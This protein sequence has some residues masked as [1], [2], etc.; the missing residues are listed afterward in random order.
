VQTDLLDRP[1]KEVLD[2]SISDEKQLHVLLPNESLSHVLKMLSGKKRA[3]VVAES[4][5]SILTQTDVLRFALTNALSM[6]EQQVWSLTADSIL[7][8]SSKPG[9]EHDPVKPVTTFDSTHAVTALKKM[10]LHHIN[11]IA[12]VNDHNKLVASLSTSDLKGLSHHHLNHLHQPVL[13]FLTAVHKR[14]PEPLV[15]QR[16]TTFRQ[17]VE[18]L[19]EFGVHRVWVVDEQSVPVGVITQ[20]DLIALLV[21]SAKA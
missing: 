19:L 1:I 16:T 8:A 17:I 13:M 4:Q 9:S 11:G 15:C 20:S 10:Y 18:R 12:I 21:T 7:K 14:V 3:L 5:V 2:F 6:F